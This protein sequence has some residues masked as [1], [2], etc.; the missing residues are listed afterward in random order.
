MSLL[1]L[2]LASLLAHGADAPADEVDETTTDELPAVE[3]EEP[4]PDFPRLPRAAS[5][6]AAIH[7]AAALA[8]GRGA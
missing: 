6:G 3:A 1:T 4:V 7:P 2:M 8:E 5:I